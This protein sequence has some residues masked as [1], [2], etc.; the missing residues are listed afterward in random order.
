MQV[1][2]SKEMTLSVLAI[3]KF[4]ISLYVAYISRF[5]EFCADRY[6]WIKAITLS[7][8]HVGK[9]GWYLQLCELLDYSLPY[10]DS[11]V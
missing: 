9:G 4:E 7:V 3:S 8:V 6:R 1:F 2:R 5:G 10:H 11:D